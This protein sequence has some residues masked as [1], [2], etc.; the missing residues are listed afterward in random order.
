MNPLKIHMMA[1]VGNDIGLGHW[2]RSLELAR[3]LLQ[4]KHLVFLEPIND[5]SMPDSL[6]PPAVGSP[7]SEKANIQWIDD[8]LNRKELIREADYHVS[9]D[10]FTLP[11]EPFD[12]LVN[13]LEMTPKE[14]LSQSRAKRLVG[15]E[16]LL[17]P[18]ELAHSTEPPKE[19]R[20][21]FV[22]GGKDIHQ[23]SLGVLKNIFSA[24]QLPFKEITVIL[25]PDHPDWAA[26]ESL[27]KD[28]RFSATLLPT[29]PSLLPLL[30]WCSVVLSGGGLTAA[31]SVLQNRA[32]VFFPQTEHECELL[33]TLKISEK[34]II[35]LEAQKN[36]AKIQDA[37]IQA[38]EHPVPAGAKIDVLGPNR[39]ADELEKL[40]GSKDP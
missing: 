37:L 30:K 4:R 7:F 1:R 13:A 25:R 2:S 20:L 6:L 29:Q 11:D 21:L 39:I 32:G 26:V 23:I 9:L 16:Y 33:R 3:V 40:V 12:L 38:F 10:L 8:R 31:F 27:L 28:S 19:K 24:N 34:Q 36:S 35:G 17:V 15:L 18:P 5:G 22:L 14:L